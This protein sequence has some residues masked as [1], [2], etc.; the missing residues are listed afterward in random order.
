MKFGICSEIFREWDIEKV[1]PF[2]REAGYQGLEIAPFTIADSVEQ[3]SPAERNR[4]KK[5]SEDAGVKIIGTHWLLVK[6]EGLSLSSRDGEL[7]KKTA[8]YL[9]ELVNFT[10]DIGGDIMVFGS[11][12]QRS[13]GEG[14]TYAEVKNSVKEA[15]KS[16]LAACE[17][18]KVF[19]CLEPLARTETNFMNTA[20]QAVELI[21]EFKNPFLKL[22]L[23]VK[24]MSNEAKSIPE[25]IMESRKYLKHF[26]VNDRNLGGPGFGD[27]DFAPIIGALKDAGYGGW[28]SVEVFD[29]TPGPEAIAKKSIEY[30]KK[31]V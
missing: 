11:P 21:E 22:H 20:G 24:A 1:F 8:D 31:F 27:V 15:L 12:K 23:D 30:L 6:P 18:R 14:Q 17:K 2:V 7:R 29:F 16:V 3:I 28:L 13:I 9:S 19:L 25:I 26:H 10:A 4:I 5:L